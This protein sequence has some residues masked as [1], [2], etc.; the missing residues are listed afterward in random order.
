MLYTQKFSMFCD[1][2]VVRYCSRFWIE[3]CIFTILCFV[4]FGGRAFQAHLFLSCTISRNFTSWHST[5]DQIW[6]CKP[7]L[8]HCTQLPPMLRTGFL[9]ESS[10]CSHQQ[11]QLTSVWPGLI[12]VKGKV[13]GSVSTEVTGH[14][15][16]VISRRLLFDNSDY[17]GDG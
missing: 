9:K 13:M 8:A 11:L 3:L 14:R 5:V 4:Q 16:S 15:I 7:P 17:L 2:V 1:V 12:E 10:K 6:A